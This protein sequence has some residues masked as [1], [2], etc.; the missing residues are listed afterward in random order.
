MDSFDGAEVQFGGD[1]FDNPFDDVNELS[2][3]EN[4]DKGSKKNFLE[5]QVDED[6]GPSGEDLDPEIDEQAQND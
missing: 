5:M 2:L 4:G 6:F 1:S 3:I